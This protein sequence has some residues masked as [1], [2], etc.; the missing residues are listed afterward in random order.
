MLRS[1]ECGAC[2]HQLGAAAPEG[3][4]E[5]RREPCPAPR[6]GPPPPGSGRYGA[7]ERTWSA[8]T[9]ESGGPSLYPQCHTR[10][11]IVRRPG[12][13]AAISPGRSTGRAPGRTHAG[14]AA[15]RNAWPTGR[16]GR[17]PGPVSD[18][19]GAPGC[20]K[21]HRRAGEG[22]SLRWRCADRIGAGVMGTSRRVT[23]NDV[24]AAGGVCRATV[25][26]V[27]NDDPTPDH[28]RRHPL[29]GQA[30]RSGPRLRP[31]RRR[32]GPC[33]RAPPASSS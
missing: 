11:R 21:L 2:R 9:G 17:R 30:G 22:V 5:C 1:G 25:G 4:D 14:R 16:A 12:G 33:A 10:R 23:L 28:L 13:N 3:A 26:F 29:P 8:T 18:T 15:V 31:A 6:S 27:L 32:P 7:E 19:A 20:G 24:A